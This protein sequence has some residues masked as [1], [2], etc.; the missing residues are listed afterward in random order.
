MKVNTTTRYAFGVLL[1][2]FFT[3]AGEERAFTRLG[4]TLRLTSGGMVLSVQGQQ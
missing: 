1:S 2:I 3:S 4:L